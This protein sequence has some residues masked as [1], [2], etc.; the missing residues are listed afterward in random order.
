MC[1]HKLIASEHKAVS[2]YECAIAELGDTD[3]RVRRVLEEIKQDEM[4]H[5]GSLMKVLEWTQ[6]EEVQAFAMGI[7]EAEEV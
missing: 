4:K 1:I 3:G 5:I 6:T 7:R 2:E